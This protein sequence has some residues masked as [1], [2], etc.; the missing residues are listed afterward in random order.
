LTPGDP[1]PETIAFHSYAESYPLLEGEAYESFK[2]DIAARGV[3]EALKYRVV[4]GTKEGLDGRNRLRACA[5]LDIHCPEEE[6]SVEDVEVEDYIDSLNLHRRHLT[7]EQRQQRAHRMRARGKTVRDI[8]ETLGVGKSTVQRDISDAEASAGVPFGTPDPTPAT[9]R[10]G[11]SG[12]PA[13]SGEVIGRD[14]KTYS[15]RKPRKRKVEPCETCARK[16]AP[17]CDLCRKAFPNGFPKR[18]PKNG[19]VLFDIKPFEQALGTLVR[20][21]DRLGNAYKAKESPEAEALRDD[22]RQFREKYHS[23]HKS[24]TG[25]QK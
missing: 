5:D 10:N 24:L 9:R 25:G 18:A 4:N 20:E 1:M 22:L 17:T 14:G 2:A 12:E 23:W 13:Q 7:R 15:A 3:R 21:I 19:A 11:F 6:V 8:A 16:G